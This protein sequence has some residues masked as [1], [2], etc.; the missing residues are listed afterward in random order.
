MVELKYFK[1]TQMKRVIKGIDEKSKG[2]R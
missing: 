2:Y 1:A